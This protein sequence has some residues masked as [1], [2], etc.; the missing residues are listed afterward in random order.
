MKIELS[1]RRRRHVAGVLFV[2]LSL[3]TL[4]SLVSYRAPTLGYGAWSMSNACGPLGA[5]LAHSLFG[6][7]GRIAAYGVPLLL[8]AWGANRLRG[9]PPGPLALESAFGI[10][11]TVEALALA[12]LAGSVTAPWTG[13]LGQGIAGVA[14]SLLGT[15]GGGIAL[16]ALFLVSG[17]VASEIGFGLVTHAWRLF[18]KAPARAVLDGAREKHAQAMARREA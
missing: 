5:L 2:A 3:L 8:F 10:L 11:L 13:S 16:G 15:I 6:V 18:V 4:V 17:L 7:F 12:G 14:R 9:R 1:E